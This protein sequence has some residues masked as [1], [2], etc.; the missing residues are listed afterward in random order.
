MV[1]GWIVVYGPGEGASIAEKT[2]LERALHGWT[3]RS[4]GYRYERPGLLTGKPHLRL[5]KGAVAVPLDL[6]KAVE[7]AVRAN[8]GWAWARKVELTAAE[9]KTL[10]PVASV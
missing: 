6:G 4:R 10:Y 8:G 2:R 1:L 7:G 3:D 5:A 9:A